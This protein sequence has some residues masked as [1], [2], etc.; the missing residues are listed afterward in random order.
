M[1]C[2]SGI[3]YFNWYGNSNDCGS[4]N[5]NKTIN[6]VQYLQWS[7]Q[8]FCIYKSTCTQCDSTSLQM[9]FSLPRESESC[10]GFILSLWLL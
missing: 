6:F 2:D 7:H 10:H 5:N 8:K 9:P 3:A 1:R 4:N